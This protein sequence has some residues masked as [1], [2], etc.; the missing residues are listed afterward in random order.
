MIG[1]N[2]EVDDFPGVAVLLASRASGY[3]TGQTLFVD[4]G[5]S[6]A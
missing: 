5:F 6:S 3:V 2:G 4:G 1:R